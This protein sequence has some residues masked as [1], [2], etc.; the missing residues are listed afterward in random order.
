MVKERLERMN[1][2]LKLIEKNG[3]VM[4][5]DKIIGYMGIEYGLSERKIK[6][7]IKQLSSAGKLKVDELEGLVYTD[8]AKYKEAA[9]G[10]TSF[11]A[12]EG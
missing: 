9:K 6:E 12:K 4:H 7:Y 1:T 5:I 10:E 3:G 8:E 11:T 2:L